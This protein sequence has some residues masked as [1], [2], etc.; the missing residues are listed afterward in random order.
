[1]ILLTPEVANVARW[2]GTCSTKKFVEQMLCFTLIVQQKQI[3]VTFKFL[4]YFSFLIFFIKNAFYKGF[5]FSL[6]N[7]VINQYQIQVSLWRKSND[8]QI[9][10]HV[11]FLSIFFQNFALI[12]YVHSLQVWAVS[13]PVL[14]LGE[15]RLRGAQK[16]L[17]MFVKRTENNQ[18]GV[19]NLSKLN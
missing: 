6:M 9:A 19:Q 7:L 15:L 4:S 17:N 3:Y 11:Y 18:R 2:P 1:M 10:V 5:L 14:Q 13:V 8:T 16:W 12:C